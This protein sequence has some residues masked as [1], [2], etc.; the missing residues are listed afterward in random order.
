MSNFLIFGEHNSATDDKKSLSLEK[1]FLKVEKST[2]KKEE[3][4]RNK[5]KPLYYAATI[6]VLGSFG[7]KNE[8]LLNAKLTKAQEYFSPQ[9]VRSDILNFKINIFEI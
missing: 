3:T 4:K 6:E 7:V 5:W 1:I 9:K 8:T 2:Q